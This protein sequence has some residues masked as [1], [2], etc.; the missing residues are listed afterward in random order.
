V[1]NVN[2][3]LNET[4]IVCDAAYIT[5]QSQ[6]VVRLKNTSDM[7]I[8]YRWILPQDPLRNKVNT[9]ILLP[10]TITEHKTQD[11]E[12]SA[13]YNSNSIGDRSN[14]NSMND[15]RKSSK[16]TKFDKEF[17]SCLAEMEPLAAESELFSEMVYDNASGEKV[18]PRILNKLRK[19]GFVTTDGWMQSQLKNQ[20]MKEVKS[21]FKKAETALT[22]VS[23]FKKGKLTPD[24][25]LLASPFSIS[26]SE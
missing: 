5:K 20:K 13:L 18:K 25:E 9:S 10:E 15:S 23:T 3:T 16:I 22:A 7:R 26:S 19:N 21:M 14:V 2:L 4:D 17:R 6:K 8:S 11:L 24:Y 1:V 12:T